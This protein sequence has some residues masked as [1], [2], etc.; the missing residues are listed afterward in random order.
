MGEVKAMCGCCQNPIGD[1]LGSTLGYC[2]MC[3]EQLCAD[4]WWVRMVA[5][6]ED[7]GAAKEAK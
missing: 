4:A 3:W 7:V 2:Q 1:S 5:Y 6:G